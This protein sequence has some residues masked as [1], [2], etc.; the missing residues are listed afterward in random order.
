M[1]AIFDD[2]GTELADITLSEKQQTI[3]DAGENI[4]VLYHTPQ[5]LRAVLGE[6]NGSFTLT[7]GSNDSIVTS[8]PVSL[9]KYADL[10]RAIKAAQLSA[11]T[12]GA[13]ESN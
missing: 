5:L 6:Q 10:Q 12:T 1:S 9:K 7:K 2:N 4:V 11:L 3:L 13:R 8:D